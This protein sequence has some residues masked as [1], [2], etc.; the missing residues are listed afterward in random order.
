MN[1]L[2]TIKIEDR[3]GLAFVGLQPCPDDVEVGVIQPVVAESASLEPL[4]QFGEIGTGQVKDGDHIQSIR[5]NAGLLEVAGDAV[6]NHGV[7]FW[8][9]PGGVRSAVDVRTPELHGR[10]VRDQFSPTGVFEKGAA[11]F[12]ING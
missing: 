12:I 8:I 3:F 1:Q 6:K 2:W 9:E 10:L 11:Q 7:A 4:D 5:E